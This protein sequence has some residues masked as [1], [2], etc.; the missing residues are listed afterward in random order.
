VFVFW[1]TFDPCTFLFLNEMTCSFP[2]LFERK[3]NRRI[4]GLFNVQPFI[5]LSCIDNPEKKNAHKK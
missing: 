1:I 5:F 4:Y 3:K 2:A